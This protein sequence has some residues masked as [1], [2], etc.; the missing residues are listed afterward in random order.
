[1]M[2]LVFEWIVMWNQMW[3]EEIIG[4]GN[5]AQAGIEY[6]WKAGRDIRQYIMYVL[7]L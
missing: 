5:Q 3:K 4:V 6:F 7:Y 2:W 1:M